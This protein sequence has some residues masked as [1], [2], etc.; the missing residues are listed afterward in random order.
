MNRFKVM[1]ASAFLGLAAA[2]VALPVAA[3]QRARALGGF[4][5][6]LQSDKIERPFFDSLGQKMGNA[7]T[8]EYRGINEVGLKGF[9]AIRQL[10]SGLFQFLAMLRGI[11]GN[12]SNDVSFAATL[13]ANEYLSAKFK[14]TFEIFGQ[15]QVGF[16]L[17]DLFLI[18]RIYLSTI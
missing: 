1:A 16:I 7:F 12:V 3:Q 9:D 17:K 5:G 10:E 4:T 13:L 6:L 11:Q 2:S 18:I 8:V 15:N 14:I